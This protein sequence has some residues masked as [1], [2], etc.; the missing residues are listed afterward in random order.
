MSPHPVMLYA[1]ALR[2]SRSDIKA[3]KITDSYSLHRV[4]YDLFD[5]VRSEQQKQASVPSGILYADKGGDF[6]SRLIL[7]LADRPPN[8]SPAFGEVESKTI[9]EPFLQ[10]S[11]YA[12]EV[13]VNP[14]KRDKQTGKIVPVRGREAITGWFIDRAE[15]SWGFSVN[16]NNLQIEKMAV[17]S[18]KKGIQTIT[19]GSATLKGELHVNDRDR[20]IQSFRQGIG[21]GRA[22]GFGLLQIV[23]LN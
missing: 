17:Q 11:R 18:F 8:P 7:M 5:D 19:H 14:G 4:V 2:L 22:F 12:F 21:R 10:H 1:S 9:N 13:T 6:N 20:F 16:P 15:K 3:L 23:P